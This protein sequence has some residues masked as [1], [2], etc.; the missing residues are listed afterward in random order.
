MKSDAAAI[1]PPAA[2]CG[3]VD[4]RDDW[5]GTIQN[6]SHHTF[7]DKVLTSPVFVRHTVGLF[8]IATGAECPGPCTGDHATAN[9]LTWRSRFGFARPAR[10]ECDRLKER[11]KVRCHLRVKGVGPF[12]PVECDQQD[13]TRRVLVSSV[14]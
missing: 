14:S 8:E 5:D 9:R 3:T 1:S 2:E 4:G 13:V 7:E 12:R 6:A 10:I 11:H